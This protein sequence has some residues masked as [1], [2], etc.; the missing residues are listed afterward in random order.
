MKGMAETFIASGALPQNLRN[1]AQV[2][3]VLQAG[4]EL[5]MKPME[6]IN[7]LYLVNGAVN[8][9]GKATTKLVRKHGWSIQ[10]SEPNTDTCVA[11][12][13]KEKES[14]TETATFQDAQKS[15]FTAK[16]GKI[17]FSWSEGN[18]RKLKLRYMALSNLI[19]TY[20]P[21]VLDGAGDIQEVADDYVIPN[22]IIAEQKTPEEQKAQ[23]N[24]FVAKAKAKKAAIQDAIIIEPDVDE[25]AQEVN[26]E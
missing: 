24:D 17:K 5:G 10:Y 23:V 15:G 19:K 12:I 7:S 14:Y 4:T 9:W 18:N 2:V 13:T 20:I 22:N 3:V 25:P 8:V 21:E 11:T 16:D 26:N 6:A 1:V